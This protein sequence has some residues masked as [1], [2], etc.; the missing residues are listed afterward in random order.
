MSPNYLT[1]LQTS[2][3]SNGEDDAT[4]TDKDESDP[5]DCFDSTCSSP[6]QET[7]RPKRPSL[8]CSRGPPVQQLFARGTEVLP[9]SGLEPI[10]DLKFETKPADPTE[11]TSLLDHEKHSP[12]SSPDA[13]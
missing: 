6:E 2:G 13:K 12:P 1:S 3:Y 9:T 4:V 7:V 5:E 10:S 11:E 8:T